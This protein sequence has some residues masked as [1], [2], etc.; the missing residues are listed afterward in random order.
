LSDANKAL[1]VSPDDVNAYLAR[2]RVYLHIGQY[3]N[4]VEDYTRCLQDERKP[5][6]ALRER[7]LAHLLANDGTKASVEAREF[8]KSN[9]W[10]NG[11]SGSAAL[12]SWLSQRQ[13]QDIDG[14]NGILNEAQTHLRPTQW[15]YPIFKYLKRDTTLAQLSALASNDR[16]LTDVKL[17]SAF[18]LLL[19]GK[20]Q[21]AAQSFAW[22]RHNGFQGDE[23]LLAQNR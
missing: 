19:N 23:A 12:I 4:A 8:L 7:A 20:K 11:L 1:Q 18:N 22:V 3:S 9:G 17:W 2:A 16:E 15:P 21:E 13:L 6:Y 10:G 14:A 5:L